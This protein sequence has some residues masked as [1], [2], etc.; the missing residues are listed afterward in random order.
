VPLAAQTS[1]L[2]PG[3]GADLGSVI[4]RKEGPLGVAA[5]ISWLITASGGLYL[6]V[7]WLIENDSASRGAAA[8]RLPLSVVSGHALLAAGGLTVWLGYLLTGRRTLAWA[9][10]ATLGAITLLGLTLAGRWIGVYRASRPAA[11]RAGPGTMLAVP[12]ER[13]F[14]LLVVLG[15]GLLATLTIALV[16]LA[17]LGVG[18]G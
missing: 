11:G 8:S 7:I 18:A 10:V 13:N 2:T 6:L 15:H 9:S 4:S 12:A 1:G 5:L 3:Q 17:A 16:V 14:P